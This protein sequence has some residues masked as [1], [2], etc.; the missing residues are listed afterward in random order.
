ML[1]SSFVVKFLDVEQSTYRDYLTTAE[2]F[3]CIAV[4]ESG[5]VPNHW[6]L[7]IG[8]SLALTMID[9]LLG[10]RLVKPNRWRSCLGPTRKS[11]RD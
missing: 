4:F 10:G 5:G 9:C 2:S 3:G 11:R 7:D 1:Q 6:L 8:Q